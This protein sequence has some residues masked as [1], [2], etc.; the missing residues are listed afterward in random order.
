MLTSQDNPS[1]IS[2][3]CVDDDEDIL[4]VLKNYFEQKPDFSVFTCTTPAEALGLISQYQF[5]AIISDYAMPEMN[6]IT[7]LKEIRAQNDQALFIIFT[8]RHLAQVAIETLNNGGN[9]YI[10]KGVDVLFD[11]Q[12]VENFIRTSIYNRRLSHDVPG[13]DTRYR[14]LVEQQPD[15]LC[16]FLPDGTCTLANSAYAYFISRKETEISQTN[17][18]A[19]IPKNE[20]ERIQKHLAS[21]TA[22]YPGTY[23]EHHV[24]NNKGESLLFQWSYRAFFNDEGNVSEYLAQGRDLSYVVRLDEILPHG[25]FEVKSAG[26]QQVVSPPI[27]GQTTATD[28]ASLADSIGQVQ[29]PIFAIDKQ[30]VV[31]AWNHAIAELTGIDARTIIG[32]EIM[33]MRSRSMANHARCSSMLSLRLLPDRTLNYFPASPVTG[34]P[35]MGKLS[36]SPLREKQCRSGEKGPRFLMAKAMSS[37]RSSPCWF[38]RNSERTAFLTRWRNIISAASPASFSKLPA[39]GLAGQ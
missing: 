35:T 3:L 11:I 10:Q 34:I 28:L 6:G 37:L 38:M 1:P 19:I 13:S 23:I 31:I 15:L 14:S 22:Q 25:S 18:L 9:Y 17:F 32:R 33:P 26:V 7:F 5:D 16:C 27:P 20:R 12:K 36:E 30:G 39:R 2:L 21:L 29:Y 24:L 8:G 4:D